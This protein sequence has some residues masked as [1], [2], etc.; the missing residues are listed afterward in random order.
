MTERDQVAM[1]GEAPAGEHYDANDISQEIADAK[2][3]RHESLS[4]DEVVIVSSIRLPKPTM[5][6]VRA[7]AA[8]LG[9]K[10]T[11]L[12][13]SWIEEKLG[14]SDPAAP[15]APV[16]AA[17]SK[18]VHQAVREELRSAGLARSA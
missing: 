13:R 2:L 14:S 15:S 3:E 12:I 9:V 18:V 16:L 5:D 1:T 7:A 17:W 8:E 4:S 6:K 11:A 10:P